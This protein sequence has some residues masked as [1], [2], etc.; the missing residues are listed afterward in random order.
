MQVAADMVVVQVGTAVAAA[1]VV[2]DREA[3]TVA[4]QAAKAGEASG[5]SNQ[6]NRCIGPTSGTARKSRR[7]GSRRTRPRTQCHW[8]RA[9]GTPPARLVRRALA[10]MVAG[11][12][13]PVRE[14]AAGEM[15]DP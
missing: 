15:V 9:A 2:A 7:T 3:A 10:M 14:V 8:C 12:V 5:S 4:K 13:A 11:W 1:R 6:C